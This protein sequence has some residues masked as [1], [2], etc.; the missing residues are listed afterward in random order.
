MNKLNILITGSGSIYGSA[1]IQSLLN[2]KLNVHLVATD[3]H[4]LAIGLH[5]AHRSYLVPPV[6]E[7]Q[8]YLEKVLEILTKEKIHALFIASAQELPF[9]SQYKALI[10]HQTGAKVFTNTTKVLSICNDKWNTVN[11]LKEHNFHF[12]ITI[13]YPEDKE[14]ISSFIQEVGF[15]FIA[16]PRHGK[17]SEDIHVVKD[18]SYL[19]LVLLEKKDMIFQQYLPNDQEEYTVGICCGENGKVLSSIA[20]K[21]YLQD[22]ITMV[23]KSDDFN[24]I[25][26]YCQE[27]AKALKPYGPCNFQLRLW[28]GSPY[29]FEINPRF[30]STTGMR[31]LLGVNEP[32]ILLQAELL[33]K[34]IQ[35]IN[36]LKSTVIRQYSDTLVPTEQIEKLEQ[37]RFI[38]NKE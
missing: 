18:L 34:D 36:I 1:V 2:S 27:I 30:S 11:F 25:T 20:L 24:S 23:A 9:Y 7:E 37:E 3:T 32:E 38:D 6:K 12:P 33:G 16:K 22:G 26:N 14:Q 10:E 17:G 5:I 31:A 19:K 15:P 29:I 21:R 28:N 8:H 4:S 35:E 13:R